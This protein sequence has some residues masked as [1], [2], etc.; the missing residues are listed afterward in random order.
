VIKSGREEERKRGKA[1]RSIEGGDKR[2]EG[3]EE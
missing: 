2:K 1:E 3:L